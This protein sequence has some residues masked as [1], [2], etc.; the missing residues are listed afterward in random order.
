MLQKNNSSQSSAADFYRR[1]DQWIDW[2]LERDD[3]HQTVR[4]VGVWLARRMNRETGD[5]WFKVQTIAVR[6][7]VTPR[8][9]IRALHK[10]EKDGAILVI[11]EGRRG[12]KRAVNRYR[13]MLL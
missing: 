10:L 4:L 3:M 11:R 2:I 5:T 9:V 6:L 12:L 8:T 13:L 1:R 7:G